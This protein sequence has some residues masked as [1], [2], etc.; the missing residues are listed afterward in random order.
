MLT[1]YLIL[2]ILGL[3]LV[4]L[5]LPTLLNKDKNKDDK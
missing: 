4:L 2:A 3:G 5:V 1:I